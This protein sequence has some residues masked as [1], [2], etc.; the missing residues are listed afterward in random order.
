MSLNAEFAKGQPRAPQRVLLMG[1]PGSG[2]S[3]VGQVLADSMGVP[4]ISTGELLRQQVEQ[5]TTVGREAARYLSQ[6]QYAPDHVVDQV[7]AGRLQQPDAT[8]GYVLDG[9]PRT[10]S[11]AEAIR[12]Q[13]DSVMYLDLPREESERRMLNRG[14]ADDIPEVI[15]DRLDLYERESGAVRKALPAARVVDARRPWQGL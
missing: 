4:L 3:T 14:R 6:G 2:K 13:V 15:K 9:Y 8:A 1:P 12:D 5:D 11:Q 10:V 7:L